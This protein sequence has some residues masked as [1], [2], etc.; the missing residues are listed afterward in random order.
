M[1]HEEG[2]SE[3]INKKEA[4][5]L[6]L[7]KQEHVLDKSKPIGLANS[8]PKWTRLSRMDNGLKG[9]SDDKP[10]NLLGKRRP[11]QITEEDTNEDLVKQQRKKSKTQDDD[12][13][14]AGAGVMIHPC[15]PQ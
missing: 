7:A 1:N 14:H 4:R 2:D 6:L 9:L 11:L 5:E 13:P 3:A 15:Q 10:T 8:K 12:T